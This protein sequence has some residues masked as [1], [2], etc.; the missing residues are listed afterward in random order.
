MFALLLGAVLVAAGIHIARL[1]V[2]TTERMAEVAL[3]WLLVGYCGIP[4]VAVSIFLLARPDGAAEILG[5]TPGNPFQAFLGW[6]YLGMSLI[7]AGALRYRGT[8]LV[9]PAVCW[10]V[11]FAGATAVHL[12]GAHGGA[13]TH[14]EAL[15]ILATHGLISV[16][17]A[18][19]LLAGASRPGGRE[20][21]RMER[22]ASSAGALV[23]S[24]HIRPD[25]D[26]GTGPP[27]TT[28]ESLER[29]PESGRSS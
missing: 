6:A 3:R 27:P 12:G 13:T 10:A 16:L 15:R 20:A 28:A 5:F 7:A 14:V 8:Y 23:R 19:A 2:R 25:A 26:R 11:F 9:G 22:A 24:V 18:V 1:A 29:R 21:P 17:L 4:M